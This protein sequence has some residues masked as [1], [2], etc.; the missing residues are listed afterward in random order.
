[1][2]LEDLRQ[3]AR[4]DWASA[5]RAKRDYWADEYRRV[6]PAAAR[7]ASTLLLDHARRLHPGFPS[8]FDRAADLA[9]HLVV[10]A[11]LDR[12]ARAFPSR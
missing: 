5:E 10:C 7:H 1:M 3:F 8:D 9:Y 12:A 11:H 6:G 2:R 4:R